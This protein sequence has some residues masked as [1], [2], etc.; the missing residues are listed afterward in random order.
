MFVVAEALCSL[1]QPKRCGRALLCVV[2]AALLAAPAAPARGQAAAAPAY[3]SLPS[4]PKLALDSKEWKDLQRIKN[5]ILAG[6]LSFAEN[7]AQFDGWYKGYM[8]PSFTN[9][10]ELHKLAVN[11]DE[12]RRDLRATSRMPEV[13]TALLDLTYKYM[14]GIATTPKYNFHPASRI[15][16]MLLLGELNQNEGPPQQKHPDP[17]PRAL[18]GVLLPQFNNAA[19][20]DFVRGAALIGILR[21]AQYDCPAGRTAHPHRH[22]TGRRASDDDAHRSQG[23]SPQPRR[24]DPRLDATSCH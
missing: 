20:S 6:S 8:L 22:T 4:D 16:A 1:P 14:V 24:E 13:R 17:L 5:Q 10:N 12:L 9:V 2:T 23:S 11:R 7:R 15:N 18:D 19:Q 3:D 21:H